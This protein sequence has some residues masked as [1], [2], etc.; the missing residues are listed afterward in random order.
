MMTDPVDLV[1]LRT[2]AYYDIFKYPLTEED[3]TEGCSMFDKSPEICK[4]A[5]QRLTERGIIFKLGNFYALTNNHQHVKERIA[6]NR[7]AEKWMKKAH[8]FSRLIAGFPY[9]RGIALSGS[10]SKGFIGEDPDIDYFIIT[11]PNRLWLA[12]TLLVIFKKI[13][14]LNSYKY[15]CINYFIDTE[16][17]EIEEK[18]LFTATELITLKPVYG[19]EITRKFFKN[20]H[21]IENYF[22]NFRHNGMD[23]NEPDQTRTFKRILE[24]LLNGKHGDWL[25]TRFM[26]IT[27]KHWARKFKHRYTEE[28]FNLV[29]KSDKKISKHHPQNFQKKVLR[30]YRKRLKVLK[31]KFDIEIDTEPAMTKFN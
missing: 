6:G 8:R 7:R 17:L 26:Q 29:F 13:F 12:R 9:V 1:I 23:A 15:F 22:P 11:E 31:E 21:W 16:N 25:D 19:D 24:Y 5:L 3:I 30:E 10:L 28:E 14:L 2:L 18:N 27:I 4:K 20:N